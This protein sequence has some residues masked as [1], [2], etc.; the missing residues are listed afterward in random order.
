MP[1]TNKSSKVVTRLQKELP[2][3]IIALPCE[4]KG[5]HEQFDHANIGN[6]AHPFRCILIGSPNCGKSTIVKNVVMHQQPE[7]DRVIVWHCDPETKVRQ[8]NMSL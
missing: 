1:T 8:R 7:F 2:Q 3:S 5:F 4:D 6:L